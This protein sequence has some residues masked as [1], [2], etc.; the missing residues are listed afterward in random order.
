MW[1]EVHSCGLALQRR[2]EC[3]DGADEQCGKQ[4]PAVLCIMLLT[5]TWSIVLHASLTVLLAFHHLRKCSKTLGALGCFK[6]LV[7]KAKDVS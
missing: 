7:G 3:P 1:W 5:Y 2:A 4:S 6:L